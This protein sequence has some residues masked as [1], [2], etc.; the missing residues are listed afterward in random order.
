MKKLITVLGLYLIFLPLFS[1]R[2]FSIFFNYGPNKLSGDIG[3]DNFTSL[4]NND[5]GRTT[6]FGLRYTLPSNFGFRIYGEYNQYNGKDTPLYNGD[7][8]SS[9]HSNLTGLCGQVEYIILGNSYTENYQPHSLY[10]FG[11]GNT[12][13]LRAFYYDNNSENSTEIKQNIFALL[14]G[15]GYQ[16]RLFNSLGIGIEIKQK[17]F[18][19]DKIDGF[20]RNSSGNKNQDTASDLILTI[21][22]F[23]N[24]RVSTRGKWDIQN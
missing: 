12:S 18:L 13:T 6:A 20:Y 21:S 2:E 15:I 11:G 1:Q 8:S 14:G 17:L 4:L 3:G 10:V 23:F 7:R 22:Y 19:S 9:F 16:Y 24:K 5:I